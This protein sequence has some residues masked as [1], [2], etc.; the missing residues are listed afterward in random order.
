MPGLAEA[1]EGPLIVS[2][3]GDCFSAK[4]PDIPAAVGPRVVDG[5]VVPTAVPAAAP[6][7]PGV[8]TTDVGPGVVS[9]GGHYTKVEFSSIVELE[10]ALRKL[11]EDVS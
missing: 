1:D 9:V 3:N 5:E 2:S 6:G 7:I 10:K 11:Y 4:R 8:F